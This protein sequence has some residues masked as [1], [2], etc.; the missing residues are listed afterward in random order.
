MEYGDYIDNEWESLEPT[1]AEYVTD[2]IGSKFFENNSETML[3]PDWRKR[4]AVIV[5][6]LCPQ[7]LEKFLEYGVN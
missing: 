4:G 6:N 5:E 1:Y 2:H 3:G 7:Y